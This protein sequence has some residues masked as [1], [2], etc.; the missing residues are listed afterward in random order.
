MDNLNKIVKIVVF[1]FILLIIFKTNEVNNFNLSR[2]QNLFFKE[3]NIINPKQKSKNIKNKLTTDFKILNKNISSSKTAILSNKEISNLDRN[4]ISNNKRNI[5]DVLFVNGCDIIKV[6]NS[7]RY[8]VLHQMEQLNAG[9]LESDE[10][11][12]ENLDPLIVLNYR[13]IIFFRCPWTEKIEEAISLAR[14]L[15]KKILFDIDFLVFDT[16]YTDNLHYLK[17]ISINEKALYDDGVI[18]IG[19]TLKQCEGTITTTKA[20]ARELKNYTPNVF[21]NHNVA[22]EEMWKL[23][24]KALRRRTSKKNDENIIIGYFG[25]IDDISPDIEAI[26]PV[27]VKILR[28]FKNVKFLLFGEPPNFLKKFPSQIISKNFVN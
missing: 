10:Y 9:F 21:I 16:K 2:A 6:P 8:R 22:S 3:I 23:S 11:Y 26:K 27:L 25:I 28:E 5:K 7:Y 19:K 14:D 12:Y 1:I 18:R 20:L 24:Q 15:N 4:T 13:V 17:T